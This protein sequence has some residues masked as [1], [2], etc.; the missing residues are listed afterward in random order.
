MANVQIDSY[1]ETSD[2]YLIVRID[3]DCAAIGQ[4]YDLSELSFSGEVTGKELDQ[5]IKLLQRAKRIKKTRIIQ[6]DD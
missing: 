1:L 3:M 4:T 6:E 2:V 5:V